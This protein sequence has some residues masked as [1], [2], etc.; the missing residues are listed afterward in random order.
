MID[1]ENEVYTLVAQSLRAE[2]PG[3][4]VASEYTPSPAAFPHVSFYMADSYN[5]LR[6]QD[7]RTAESLAVMM[8]QVDVYSNKAPG[9]KTECKKI[10]RF[11][12][13]LLYT[14]NFL[15][16]S[17]VPTPNLNDATIYRITSRYR[18]ASDGTHFFRR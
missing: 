6:D 9:K 13:D 4:D 11:I 7:G 5:D 8:F 10:S 12:S 15:R 14:K 1:P 16:S 2:F 18:V 3:I 17:M